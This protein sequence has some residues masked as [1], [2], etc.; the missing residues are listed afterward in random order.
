MLMGEQVVALGIVA[1]LLVVLAA[2]MVQSRKAGHQS[3][4]GYEAQNL[5]E[6]RLEQLAN[7]GFNQYSPGP[8]SAASGRLQDGTPYVLAA[9]VY[10]PGLQGLTAQEARR[11]R[12]VVSWRDASGNHQRQSESCFARVQ[13]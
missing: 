2:M 12:V 9:E 13:K 3:Q 7:L 6:N 4:L 11:I 8:Q 1:I 5:A 10:S